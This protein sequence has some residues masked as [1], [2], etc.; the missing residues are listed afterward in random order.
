[1]R[2]V[3]SCKVETLDSFCV[4]R[5]AFTIEIFGWDTKGLFL[6]L[7]LSLSHTHTHP[8]TLVHTRTH[9]HTHTHTWTHTHMHAH[10]HTHASEGCEGDV[11]RIKRDIVI[12]VGALLLHSTKGLHC[13]HCV[14]NFEEEWGRYVN[15]EVA[16]RQLHVWLLFLFSP[17]Y[18]LSSCWS[19]SFISMQTGF[20]WL[21]LGSQVGSTTDHFKLL[22]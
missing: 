4:K 19:F 8:H 18:P 6:S 21:E 20:Q 1:M 17:S 5:S 2:V 7:S 3:K 13:S 11:N 10:T 16:R 9:T 15:F 22:P 14:Q 12:V